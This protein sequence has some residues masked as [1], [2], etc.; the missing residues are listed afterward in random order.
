VCIE[1]AGY[2]EVLSSS[3]VWLGWALPVPVT[4]GSLLVDEG[5][6]VCASCRSCSRQRK[7]HG[8]GLQNFTEEGV[9]SFSRQPTKTAESTTSFFQR[10]FRFVEIYSK[11]H[12]IFELFWHA[13]TTAIRKQRRTNQAHSSLLAPRRQHPQVC[14]KPNQTKPNQTKPNQTT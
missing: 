2:S 10:N 4:C 9:F 13:N 6:V 5:L 12:L 1:Y 14:S 3:F 7:Q 11:C 8:G